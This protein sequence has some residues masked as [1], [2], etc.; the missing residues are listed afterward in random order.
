M[1][2]DLLNLRTAVRN[3]MQDDEF[4]DHV[5]N[6]FINDANRWI[7]NAKRWRFMETTFSGTV[8]SGS[9]SYQ[10]PT[11]FQAA[12]SLRL[13]DPD[14]VARYIDYADYAQFD[15]D[16]PDPTATPNATPRTWYIFG[17]T[18]SLFPAPDTSYTME[19]RYLKSPT[20]MTTDTQKPDVPE[21]FQELVVLAA[22]K[23][24]AQRSDNYDIGQVIDQEIAELMD[25]M[26]SRLQTRQIGQLSRMRT[27]WRR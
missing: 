1:A 5:L 10:L 9:P 20:E 17:K 12:V 13:V 8:A 25:L 19:I 4:P 11:D 6:Q 24:A 23:R 14:G 16:Y 15:Q 26:E 7:C 22:F 27:G 3:K 21:E 18:L 2:Y